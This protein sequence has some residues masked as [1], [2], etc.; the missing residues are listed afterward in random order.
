MPSIPSVLLVVLRRADR[1][2]TAH[3]QTCRPC[4]RVAKVSWKCKRWPIASLTPHPENCGCICIAQLG[5]GEPLAIPGTGVV[6]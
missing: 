3:G 4:N 1:I 2:D 6:L 5:L